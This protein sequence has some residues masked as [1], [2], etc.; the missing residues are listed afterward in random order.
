MSNNNDVFEMCI[1]MVNGISFAYVNLFAVLESTH[2][3]DEAFAPAAK[4]AEDLAE[5]FKD[6]VED[7]RPHPLLVTIAVSGFDKSSFKEARAELEAFVETLN[8]LD[9]EDPLPPFKEKI[10]THLEE[11]NATYDELLQV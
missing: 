10:L 7:I 1:E 3:P 6:F 8:M 4:S 5:V 2:L 9:V 11:M